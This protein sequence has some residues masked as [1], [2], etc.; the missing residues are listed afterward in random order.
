MAREITNEELERKVHEL[1]REAAERKRTQEALCE[2][3]EKY[4]MVVERASDGIAI[5][6]DGLLKYVNPSMAEITGYSVEEGIDTLFTNYVD[7]DEVPDAE[8]DYKRRIAGEQLPIRYERGLRHKNGSRIDTEISGGLITYQGKP[9]DLVLV[10]DI[11]ERKQAEIQILKSKAM[12]QSI[13]DGISDPVVML[14]TDMMVMMLNTAAAGYYQVE[15][16]DV[17]GKSCC[18]VL[19]RRAE[20][21]DGCKIPSAVLRGEPVTFEREGMMDPDRLERVIFYPVR[22]ADDEVEASII[23]ISDITETRYMEQ[24]LMRSEKLA[25]LGLLVSGVAHEINNPLAII[26]EKAGLMKDYMQLSDEFNHREKFLG[27]L[28]SISDSVD[29]AREIIRRFLGFARQKDGQTQDVDLRRLLEDVLGFL[30]KEAFHRNLDVQLDFSQDVPIMESDKGRL[31]EV[32]LNIIKN[33]IEVVDDGGQIS[34]TTRL[35]DPDTVR[36]SITDDGCGMFPEQVKQIFKPFHTSGKESGTGL[37][38]YIT[39]QI[40]TKELG[41]QITVQS[42]EGK[43]TTFTVELPLKWGMAKN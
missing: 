11:T 23:H 22:D 7:P 33:A 41:G 40:V 2:S 39:H 34:V 32:F 36:V 4:R 20:S 5:I 10:R 3:E 37:G 27:L 30:E 18:E 12:L 28:E 38:L 21:C 16:K 24:Q 26:N 31:Q 43:G 13:F 9:A 8:Q 25:S 19:Q 17:I 35:K 14:D 42:E 29:R 15:F 6:Q 1:E